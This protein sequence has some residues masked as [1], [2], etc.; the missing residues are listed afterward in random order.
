MELVEKEVNKILNG[1]LG[2]PSYEMA[3][4]R[5][6]VIDKVKDYSEIIVEHIIKCVVY[7]KSLGEADYYHWKNEEICGYCGLI[8]EYEVKKSGKLKKDVY[9]RALLENN[10][11]AES[12]YYSEVV[13]FRV[14]N[15][16]TQKYP[17]FKPT[18]MQ[19]HQVYI[20][21]LALI[22]EVTPVFS[23][24]SKKDD[25][26]FTECIDRAFKRAGLD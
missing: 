24:Y 2:C 17:D 12:D 5:K 13:L 1:E 18:R 6:K 20:A 9:A 26:D 14:N 25:Y 11:T 3:L 7:K 16:R 21:F 8:N 23:D 10:G 4:P 15:L 22:S 19:G